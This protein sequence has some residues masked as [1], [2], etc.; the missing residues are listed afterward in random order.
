VSVSTPAA[1]AAWE[2]RFGVEQKSRFQSGSRFEKAEKSWS[3]GDE[4]GSDKLTHSEHSDRISTFSRAVF[5]WLSGFSSQ[6]NGAGGPTSGVPAE[7]GNRAEALLLD[8]VRAGIENDFERV[9]FPKYPELSEVKRALQRQGARYAS[10]SGSGSTVYGLFDS[11][12]T[13]ESAAE[14]LTK[15]DVPAQVTRT[16]TRQQYRA[17]MF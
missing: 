11:P 4:A 12:A 8:L 13:A 7:G 15:K 5:Q 17:E 6:Q 2:E 9:V 14:A 16:L 1:F 3:A 10:L